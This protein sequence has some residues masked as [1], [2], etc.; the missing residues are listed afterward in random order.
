MGIKRIRV[1]EATALSYG[2]GDTVAP[3]WS[4][5][6]RAL[7]A[8]LDQGME[9]SLVLDSRAMATDAL[10]STWAIRTEDML[11][12]IIQK[13][14]AHAWRIEAGN[15]EPNS[16]E[17][18]WT[19]LMAG[20]VGRAESIIPVGQ[21][22]FEFCTPPPI[23]QGYNS[24]DRLLTYMTENSIRFDCVAVHYYGQVVDY[25]TWAARIKDMVYRHVDNKPIYV[26]EWGMAGHK[27]TRLRTEENAV[28]ALNTIALSAGTTSGDFQAWDFSAGIG[29]GYGHKDSD[30]NPEGFL[31][32]VALSSDHAVYPVGNMLRLVASMGVTRT[33][34]LGLPEGPL[35]AM[36]DE[37]GDTLLWNTG[38]LITVTVPCTA[39]LTLGRIDAQN[40][41]SFTIW[42]D[43]TLGGT[44]NLD[45]WTDL[46]ANR[47]AALSSP[48]NSPAPWA[49][50]GQSKPWPALACN[51]GRAVVSVPTLGIVWAGPPS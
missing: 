16:T 49:S 47:L 23:T 22:R 17:R 1:M 11:T 12:H 40:G 29:Q 21:P 30:G 42:N 27:D 4:N 18:E 37:A 48:W 38:P 39:P 44:A 46:W 43:A 20:A 10:T 8:I 35:R 3:D 5:L 32:A 19:A 28:W 45:H 14:G 36:T 51:S 7:T 24:L 9:P 31:G 2:I 15:E 6:D 25:P 26:T 41:N 50:Y 33:A 34:T 13:F